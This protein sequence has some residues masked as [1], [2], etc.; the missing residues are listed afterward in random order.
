MMCRHRYDD[1]VV[2]VIYERYDNIYNLNMEEIFWVSL[3]KM[4]RRKREKCTTAKCN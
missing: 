4:R 2:L 1:A 3:K